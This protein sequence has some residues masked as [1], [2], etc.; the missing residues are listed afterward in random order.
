MFM[1]K[2][3]DLFVRKLV[4]DIRKDGRQR[5]ELHDYLF[6]KVIGKNSEI[7]PVKEQRVGGISFK[8]F[9][10]DGVTFYSMYS[11]K[12]GSVF[13]MDANEAKAR[14]APLD[15]DSGTCFGID[16][17]DLMSGVAAV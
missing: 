11:Y 13:L 10:Y 15:K 9:E 17:S 8:E 2:S 6:A 3:I 1:A 12:D 7:S 14:F 4:G 16:F 5:V